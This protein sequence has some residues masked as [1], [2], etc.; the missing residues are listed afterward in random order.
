LEDYTERTSQAAGLTAGATHLIPLKVSVCGSLQGIMIAG[1]DAGRLVAMAA[2]RRKGGIFPKRS[3]AVVLRMVKI[4]AKYHAFFT[5]VT[6][7]EVNE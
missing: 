6:D 4:I 3:N 7:V 2:N 1:V 5:T